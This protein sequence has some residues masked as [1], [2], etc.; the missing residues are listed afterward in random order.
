[1]EKRKPHYD[2]ALVQSA[3]RIR[4]SD[5]FT[6]TALTGAHGNGARDRSGDRSGMFDASKRLLQE[7][8]DPCVESDL[9]RCLSPRDPGRNSVCKG[10][11]AEGWVHC[12]TVQGEMR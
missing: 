8:D 10:Y 7:Y 12:Y 4:G 6:A 9:A 11:F 1:M 3:V 5:A 2:L